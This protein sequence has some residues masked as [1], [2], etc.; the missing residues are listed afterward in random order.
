MPGLKNIEAIAR[1]ALPRPAC[2]LH[3]DVMLRNMNTAKLPAV[4]VP[5]KATPILSGCTGTGGSFP[6]VNNWAGDRHKG[7]DGKTH[8]G[9]YWRR[10][11]QQLENWKNETKPNS[12]KRKIANGSHFVAPHSRSTAS[13]CSCNKPFGIIYSTYTVP[14]IFTEDNRINCFSKK[15]DKEYWYL[16]TPSW[17]AGI[18]R[19]W[20]IL[21]EFF[22]WNLRRLAILPLKKRRGKDEFIMASQ[23]KPVKNPSLVVTWVSGKNP[24]SYYFAT[25]YSIKIPS[26]SDTKDL[27][28]TLNHMK[29][30]LI[31][32]NKP[33]TKVAA[34][35]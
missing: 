32:N 9:A 8:S 28:P 20:T 13:Q 2:C 22:T 31:E 35:V 17:T 16:P 29:N 34:A 1:S 18:E 30:C 11:V 21:Q 4:A 5:D 6:M 12:A 33:S 26:T 25:N 15:R 19:L 23:R 3:A 10:K 27:P 24:E 7:I 14:R